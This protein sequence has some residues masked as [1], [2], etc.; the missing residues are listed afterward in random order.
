MADEDLGAALGDLTDGTPDA[1]SILH[2]AAALRRSAGAAGTGAVASGRWLVDVTG[3]LAVRVPIRDLPTL[4]AQLGLPAGA[5]LAGRLVRNATRTSATIGGAAGAVVT[6]SEL[7][8]PTWVTIPF[9]LVVETLAVAA[10]EMKLIAELHA[11]FHR[12]L[13][14]PVTERGAVLLQAW[15]ERRGVR[16]GLRGPVNLSDV[17]GRTTRREVQRLV[18]R[19]LLGRMGRNL[20]SLAPMLAG[21]AAG[22]E[23]NRRATRALGAAVT[24]DLAETG[25]GPGPV[26]APDGR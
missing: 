7:A 24:A 10:V 12:P 21:A 5:D 11:A 22:A 9:H 17:L 13:T 15:A 20:T 3:E 19:R 25:A 14:G 23:I 16:A 1:G 4:E 2:L 8:P 26:P 18:R 6:A